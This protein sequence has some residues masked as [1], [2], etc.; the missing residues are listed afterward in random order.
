VIP[1]DDAVSA[2]APP[3]GPPDPPEGELTGLLRAWREGDAAAADEL[4]PL[5]YG[6]LRRIASQRMR[7]ERG[8]HTLQPTALVHEAFLRLVGQ[9]ID[10][11]DRGHFFA[12]ASRAMRRVAVD[13]WRAGA[14]QKRGGEGPRLELGDAA[15]PAVE[16]KSVDVMAL[17]AALSRLEQMSAQQARVVE[18]RYFAGLSLEEVAD[19]LDRSRASVFRDWRAARTWLFRELSGSVSDPPAAGTD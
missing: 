11:R 7:G 12:V 9:P 13:H 5:V 15:E 18:L 2:S 8:G 19:L 17:D 3:P 4:L 6:E 14:A 10:W 16:P 1:S